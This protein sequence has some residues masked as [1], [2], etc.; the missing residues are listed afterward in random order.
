VHQAP[1]YTLKVVSAIGINNK[2]DN[3]RDARI[4]KNTRK[5]TSTGCSN[6]VG[7]NN[8]DDDDDDAYPRSI[9]VRESGWAVTRGQ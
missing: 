6:N 9:H 4:T 2:R 7:H 5:Y 8:D 3:T 1:Y